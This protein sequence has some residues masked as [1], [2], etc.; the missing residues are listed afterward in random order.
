LAADLIVSIKDRGEEV[1]GKTTFAIV[2]DGE[3]Q[4]RYDAWQQ[5]IVDKAG[6][7][8]YRRISGGGNTYLLRKPEEDPAWGLWTRPNSLRETEPNVNLIIE[9]HRPSAGWRGAEPD[10]PPAPPP[11][12]P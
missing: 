1:S 5:Q 10:F 11:T 2:L 8:T 7:L 6:A 4:R 12:S 9:S 3:V